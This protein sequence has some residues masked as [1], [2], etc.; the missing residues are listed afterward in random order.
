V[1]ADDLIIDHS[2]TGKTVEDT[3]ER[4]PDFN[5]VAT[6]AFIVE[7]V[8]AIDARCFVVTTKNEEVFWVLDFVSKE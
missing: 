6:T 3:A 2:C 8:N 4:L 7:S 1:H 5:A